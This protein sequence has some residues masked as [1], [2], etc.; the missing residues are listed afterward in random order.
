MSLILLQTQGII[1]YRHYHNYLI[2]WNTVNLESCSITCRA[3][4]I[5]RLTLNLNKII[6][7]QM[8][9]HITHVNYDLQTFYS[10]AFILE[11]H[12]WYRF[13]WIHL[14]TQIVKEASEGIISHQVKRFMTHLFMPSQKPEVFLRHHAYF[15]YNSLIDAVKNLKGGL[16]FL[17]PNKWN[18][19][20][21]SDSL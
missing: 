17:R 3:Y 6:I 19:C 10:I 16:F 8:F 12:V 4:I 5:Y 9:N 14:H 20:L 13:I 2:W 18:I 7:S 15:F 1:I 21:V 11:L